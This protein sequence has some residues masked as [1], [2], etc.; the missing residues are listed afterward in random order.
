VPGI[1][2]LAAP[3]PMGDV[4]V[5]APAPV[6]RGGTVLG[7]AVPG[8]APTAPARPDD[9]IIP[10]GRYDPNDYAN[11]PAVKPAPVGTA[12]ANVR[13]RLQHTAIGAAPVIPAPAPPEEEPLPEAPARR[14]AKGFPIGMVAA[15]IGGLV[16]VGGIAIA[17]L[18]RSAP[19]IQAQPRL[20]AQN[21]EVLHLTC[22]NCPDGTEA[23]LDNQKATF[24][25]GQADLALAKPLDVGENKLAVAIKRKGVGRDETVTLVVPVA[26]HIRA[27]LTDIGAKP[28]VIQV[29]V[30]AA[31]GTEVTV[32]KKPLALDASGKGAYAVDVSADTEGPNPEVGLIDRKIPYT[33]TLKGGK[34]ESGLVS[35]RIAVVPL[36]VD[37]PS[38]HAVVEG[39]TF[40]LAGQAAPGSTVTIDGAAVDVSA[41]GSFAMTEAASPTVPGDASFELRASAQGRAPRTVH[42]TVKHVKSL[43]AEA[44][45][46]EAAG[47]LLAYDALAA[48]IAGSV[49]KGTVIAGEVLE[50][51]VTGHQTIALVSS[52]RGCATG[53]C[54]AR[55]IASEDA[56]P[57]ARGKQVRAYGHVTRAV[58][59]SSGKTIPE[60]EADF[61]VRGR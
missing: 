61:V 35:A 44:K 6:A 60:V 50:A 25:A 33:V 7:V 13:P 19:P 26:F 24:K 54:L 55:V 15:G 46:V 41:D 27:D 16:L 1:A 18:V 22:D 51:R 9:G 10:S 23:S 38:A 32:D 58:T 52:S 36:R 2:P 14:E 5:A 31:P 53:P 21:N 59:T 3:P 39:A 37:T 40:P 17:L 56:K 45:A 43:D 42:L 34:P 28:P 29:R 57:L 47:G 12:P 4:P 8:V 48:D 20:D 11:V 49:G 30:A